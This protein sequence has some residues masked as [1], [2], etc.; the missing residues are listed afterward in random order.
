[1]KTSELTG[2]ALDWAVAQCEGYFDKDMAWIE[3]GKVEVAYYTDYS[4]STNWSLY[5]R[6]L[7]FQKRRTKR[8][9]P[10]S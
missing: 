2:A 8:A 10:H 3:D 4:P 9:Q 7:N 6:T 1:M 5:R